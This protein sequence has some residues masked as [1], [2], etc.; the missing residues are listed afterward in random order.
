MPCPY[1]FNCDVCSA[2][3]NTGFQAANEAINAA[4]PD[5]G[6]GDHTL[7]R[8]KVS[9]DTQYQHK[10]VQKDASDHHDVSNKRKSMHAK[11]NHD[12]DDQPTQK[13]RKKD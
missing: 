10:T 2:S 8:R 11:T 7:K 5:D 1:T 4:V 6:Q 13:T 12:S 9:P 3:S